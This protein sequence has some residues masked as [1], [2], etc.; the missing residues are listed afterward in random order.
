MKANL[1]II[2]NAKFSRDG[3]QPRFLENYTLANAHWGA[4]TRRFTAHCNTL[5]RA[6]CDASPV[7][8]SLCLKDASLHVISR[9]KNGRFF[10]IITLRCDKQTS[11]K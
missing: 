1:F 6:I 5:V 10:G 11:R 4:T 8:R 9:V 7:R 2:G 3:T